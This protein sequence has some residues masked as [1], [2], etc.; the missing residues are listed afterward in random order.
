M[1]VK[2]VNVLTR[3]LQFY[4]D[5]LHPPVMRWVGAKAEVKQKLMIKGQKLNSLGLYLDS[6]FTV[7]KV[8]SC[9]TS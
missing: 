3:V 2:I 4:L 7:V 9:A 8:D 5:K 6:T 1:F